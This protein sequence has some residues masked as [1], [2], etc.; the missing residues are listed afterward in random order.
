M[1]LYLNTAG[2]LAAVFV[3]G[4]LFVRVKNL[5]DQFKGLSAFQ[6]AMAS[7]PEKFIS[8]ADKIDDLYDEVKDIRHGGRAGD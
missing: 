5:E 7:F 3:A 8:L 6:N 1:L 2:V 4:G